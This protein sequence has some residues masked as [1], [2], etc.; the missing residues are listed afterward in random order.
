MIVGVWRDLGDIFK[1]PKIRRPAINCLG[2][3][4]WL[5]KRNREKCLESDT[6]C[7]SQRGSSNTYFPVIASMLSI[8]PASDAVAEHLRNYYPMLVTSNEE[9][10]KHIL[11]GYCEVNGI[12]FELAMAWFERYHAAYTEQSAPVKLPDMKNIALSMNL[13]KSQLAASTQNFKPKQ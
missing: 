13:K 5:G 9:M 10:R 1:L 12:P 11:Q 4:P 8:P 6:L 2:Y 7:V 3:R